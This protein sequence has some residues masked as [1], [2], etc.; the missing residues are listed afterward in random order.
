MQMFDLIKMYPTYINLIDKTSLEEVSPR[1]QETYFKAE[2]NT[3]LLVRLIQDTKLSECE[4]VVLDGLLDGYY[5]VAIAKH[6]EMN[7]STVRRVRDTV[8]DKLV[9]TYQRQAD[10]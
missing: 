8:I 4:E 7:R 6:L 1:M 9:A 3:V 10:H 2:S 5:S